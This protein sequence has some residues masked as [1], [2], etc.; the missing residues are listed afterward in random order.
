MND[1]LE[2]KYTGH[3]T[4]VLPGGKHITVLSYSWKRGA[5]GSLTRWHDSALEADAWV[6][7]CIKA[8]FLGR[9]LRD[10]NEPYDDASP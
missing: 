7:E 2:R 4:K 6:D 8:I 5:T 1:Y 10:L 3:V 9:S